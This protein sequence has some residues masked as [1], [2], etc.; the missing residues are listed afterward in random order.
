V[1]P[2]YEG[3]FVLVVQVQLQLPCTPLAVPWL[4]QSSVAVHVRRQLP[5][6]N[7]LAQLAHRVVDP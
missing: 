5:P 4:L 1:A 3:P 2:V 6:L 7:P